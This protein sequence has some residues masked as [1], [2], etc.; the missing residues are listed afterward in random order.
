M[1][2]TLT[3]RVKAILN[4]PGTG[5][6]VLIAELN[7]AFSKFDNHF[8]PAC[9]IWSSVDQSLP[10]SV[11][12]GLNY[13]TTIFDS[14]AARAE[15]AMADLANDW[16]IIRKPGLYYVHASNL[17]VAGT[18]AG[19]IRSN[20]AING[21]VS[22][23]QFQGPQASAVSQ[24]IFGEYVFAANDKITCLMQQNQGSARNNTNNTYQNIF[25]LTAIWQG[26]IVEV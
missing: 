16:I 10:N 13:N 25:C 7:A 4:T 9:K 1:A 17:L 21:A 24:D 20:I 15:G 12:T 5:E 23:S 22:N 2:Q 11:Q 6:N 3:D 14:Y 26:N 19:I 8:I 18:A